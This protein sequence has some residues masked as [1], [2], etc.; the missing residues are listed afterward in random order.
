MESS[1]DG[2]RSRFRPGPVSSKNKDAHDISLQ[3]KTGCGPRSDRGRGTE[4]Q[5]DRE[6]LPRSRAPG[7][8]ARA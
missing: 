8:V 1:G 3:E 7:G 5:R 2:P 6:A 4:G